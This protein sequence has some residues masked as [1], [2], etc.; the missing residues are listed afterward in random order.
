MFY[1]GWSKKTLQSENVLKDL[2]VS[3]TFKDL[4]VTFPS[5]LSL[6]DPLPELHNEENFD[7]M[8]IFVHTTYTET[9]QCPQL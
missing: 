6:P 4:S 7:F 1:V 5:L 8:Q 3:V 9:P 2:S